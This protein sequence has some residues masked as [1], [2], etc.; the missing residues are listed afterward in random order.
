MVEGRWQRQLREATG[1]KNFPVGSWMTAGACL[2]CL[3]LLEVFVT[4]PIRRQQQENGAAPSVSIFGDATP[5]ERPFGTKPR[6][7]PDGR[8]LM[9]DGSIVRN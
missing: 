5:K 7:L 1:I 9:E 4:G 3:G 6:V 2:C 8:R